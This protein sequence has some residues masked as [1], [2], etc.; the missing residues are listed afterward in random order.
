M[1]QGD[2]LLRLQVFLSRAG[3]CSRR[4]AFAAI[5]QGD[6]KVNGRIV[7]EPSFTVCP[8]GDKVEFKN[9]EV[10]LKSCEYIL[11]NKPAGYV[12]TRSDPF[13]N[14][15]VMQL[16]PPSLR[17]LHPVG[18]LDK[19][20]RGL[21]LLTNDGQ[22]TYALTHPKHNIPKTYLVE[23]TGV[24]TPAQ[25]RKLEK[26]VRIE[27]GYFCRGRISQVRPGR[28]RTRFR[29]A[30]YEGRKR[31]I[32]LMLAGLGHKVV[33]L[34]RIALGRLSLGGLAEGKFRRLSFVGDWMGIRRKGARR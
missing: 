27:G 10:G 31:Q 30:I 22:F 32:R 16:L 34:Q 25:R 2:S 24:L 15:T 28:K 33:D 3:V 14:K 12:T 9:K 4:K 8:S 17:H 6:V 23:I 19:D 11:L 13:A 21:L 5:C 7:R 29:M 20:T 26:G 18:R 1:S